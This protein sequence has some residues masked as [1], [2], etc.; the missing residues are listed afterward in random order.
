MTGIRAATAPA[1]CPESE[2]S[3]AARMML[4]FPY[5]LVVWGASSGEFWAFPCFDAPAGTILH[6][7]D[8]H[9]LAGRM[10]RLQRV[11]TE[12]QL[13]RAVTENAFTWPADEP[14]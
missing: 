7:A 5:W 4:V 14:R 8:P 2:G 13:Q 12:M 1:V 6:D 11:V 10:H 3:M 9:A